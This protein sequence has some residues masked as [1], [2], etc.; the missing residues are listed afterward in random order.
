MYLSLCMYLSFKK[1]DISI[2]CQWSLAHKFMEN[3]PNEDKI[4]QYG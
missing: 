4:D 1:N 3:L 2:Q